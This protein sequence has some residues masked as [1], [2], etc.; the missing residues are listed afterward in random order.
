MVG[1]LSAGFTPT[2]PHG[3]PNLLACPWNPKVHFGQPAEVETKPDQRS[4]IL[5]NHAQITHAF[6]RIA[7]LVRIAVVLPVLALSA[8]GQTSNS[9][10]PPVDVTF[11]FGADVHICWN[12][13]TE[14]G[15]YCVD[16]ETDKN[17]TRANV[18]AFIYRLRK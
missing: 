12:G 13:W 4:L 8:G 2:L 1:T 3:Y 10:P 5:S 16:G 18:M 7:T 11:T 15:T 9:G 6:S 14:D 17:K